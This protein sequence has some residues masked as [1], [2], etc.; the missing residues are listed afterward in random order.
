LRSAWK[1]CSP[2]GLVVV[3]GSLYLVGDLLPLVRKDKLRYSD[4][5]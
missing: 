3:T 4:Q 2:G 1:E 5:K